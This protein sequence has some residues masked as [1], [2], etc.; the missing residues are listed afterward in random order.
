MPDHFD[1]PVVMEIYALSGQ[2]IVSSLQISNKV[3]W[4]TFPHDHICRSFLDYDIILIYFASMS[5]NVLLHLMKQ[6]NKEAGHCIQN[7]EKSL[8]CIPRL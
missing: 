2:F 4:I 7:N 8:F 5:R 6:R 3:F 1:K